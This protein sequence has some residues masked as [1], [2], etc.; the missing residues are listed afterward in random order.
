MACPE[1]SAARL[2]YR[3]RPAWVA[4]MALAT[5]LGPESA[6]PTRP[7]RAFDDRS[8]QDYGALALRD[9]AGFLL[10]HVSVSDS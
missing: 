4:K 2:E 6:P 9:E 1:V 10:E 8:C 3:W 7:K 5:E